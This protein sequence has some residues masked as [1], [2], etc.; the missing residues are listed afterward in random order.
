MVRKRAERGCKSSVS[1]QVA[2]CSGGR[3]QRG[4]RL[5]EQRRHPRSRIAQER[6]RCVGHLLFGECRNGRSRQLRDREEW[7]KSWRRVRFLACSLPAPFFRFTLSLVSQT[8]LR[9]SQVRQGVKRILVFC[10][11]FANCFSYLRPRRSAP[12]RVDLRM[13]SEFVGL[14]LPDFLRG[15]CRRL[16]APTDAIPRYDR[17]SAHA[18]VFMSSGS[19]NYPTSVLTPAKVCGLGFEGPCSIFLIIVSLVDTLRAPPYTNQREATS[20]R[21]KAFFC[22]KYSRTTGRLDVR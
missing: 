15:L 10:F 12:T 3:T 18:S 4:T 5:P 20:M 13:R 22:R 7:R 21:I 19:Q 8:A 2:R 16:D 17:T 14:L 11:S 6:C 1:V 9:H